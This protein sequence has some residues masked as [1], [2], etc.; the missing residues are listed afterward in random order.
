MPT[1]PGFI[2]PGA[3]AVAKVLSE[4]LTDGLDWEPCST[5][6][7]PKLTFKI[8]SVGFSAPLLF[9]E[10][11]F[12]YYLMLKKFLDTNGLKSLFR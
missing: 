5:S 8:C 11:K 10:K 7:V 3:C 12:P 4:L 2:T 9:D 1:I 6:P